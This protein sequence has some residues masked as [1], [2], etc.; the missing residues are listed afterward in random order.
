M[1]WPISTNPYLQAGEVGGRRMDQRGKGQYGN[2]I[3]KDEICMVILFLTT[4]PY[5][6]LLKPWSLSLK[7]I[8]QGL[9]SHRDFT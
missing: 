8:E 3:V 4:V 5:G 9:V 6:F 2:L 1:S 7:I